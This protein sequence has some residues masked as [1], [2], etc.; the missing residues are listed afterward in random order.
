M[1]GPRGPKHD[2]DWTPFLCAKWHFTDLSH[3]HRQGVIV[4]FL[5][6]PTYFNPA[7]FLY[8]REMAVRNP[9]TAT[10][11]DVPYLKAGIQQLSLH[12][13]LDGEL[14]S[15]AIDEIMSGRSP[16]VLV[17]AFLALL[18]PDKLS[19]DIII[20]GVKNMRAHA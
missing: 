14:V 20:A 2:N 16:E 17:S 6:L 15:G 9:L 7:S 8:S 13:P 11:V 12:R 19:P 4:Y 18:S 10:V 3:T 5:S 1:G